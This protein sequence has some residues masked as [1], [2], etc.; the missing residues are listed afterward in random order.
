M[1]GSILT[2]N[3]GSSSL[4]FALFDNTADLTATVRGEIEDLD[5]APHLLARDASGAVLAEHRWSAGTGHPFA[6]AL[7]SLLSFTDS[8][9]GR[10][11]L[12]GGGPRGVPCGGQRIRA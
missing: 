11:G 7:D 2:I 10:D 5:A 8:H 1:T 4:K 6:V 9:L 3:G 12:A